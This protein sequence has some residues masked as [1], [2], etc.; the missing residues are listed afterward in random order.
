MVNCERPLPRNRAC[1]LVLEID[2]LRFSIGIDKDNSFYH[3][4]KRTLSGYMQ[5]TDRQMVLNHDGLG[6]IIEKDS[7]CLHLSFL[8][9]DALKLPENHFSANKEILRVGSEEM[10]HLIDDLGTEKFSDVNLIMGYTNPRMAILAAKYL[11]FHFLDDVTEEE[12]L[13]QLEISNAGGAPEHFSVYIL[14]SEL[15]NKRSDIARIG[16]RLQKVK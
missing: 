10:L 12:V 11:G 15:L 5:S 6:I 3:S 2:P 1:Y 16:L 4:P 14:K 8:P 7:P 9:E 13:E